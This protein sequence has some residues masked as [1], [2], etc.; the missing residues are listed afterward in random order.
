M[1]ATTMLPTHVAVI[2]KICVVYLTDVLHSIPQS[3]LLVYTQPFVAC[4][5]SQLWNII[6]AKSPALR[7][8]PYFTSL[9]TLSDLYKLTVPRDVIYLNFHFILSDP[10]IL[11]R[12]LF[13]NTRNL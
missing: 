2:C 6:L 11:L 1:V 5:S 7:N 9:T 12:I 4:Y 10:A 8:L 13:P 3:Q